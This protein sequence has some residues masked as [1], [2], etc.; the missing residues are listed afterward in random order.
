MR[1]V[2]V[3][4]ACLF[5]SVGIA[6]EMLPSH[7]QLRPSYVSGVLQTQMHLFNKRQDVEY[8]E[9]AVFDE[10]F[11]PVPFVTAYRVIRL[12]YLEQLKFDVYVLADDADRAEYICSRSKLRGNGSNGAMVASRICSRFGEV[13]R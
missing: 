11:R 4:I 12:Q 13:A 7:P 3:V 6:H 1:Q 8:Y 5:S 2:V 10:D 9:I